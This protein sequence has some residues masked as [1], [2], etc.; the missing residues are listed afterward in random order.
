MLCQLSSSRDRE[1]LLCPVAVPSAPC[2]A[3]PSTS[4]QHSSH[5]LLEGRA[6]Q[7]TALCFQSP[8]FLKGVQHCHSLAHPKEGQIRE[9]QTC[10][11]LFLGDLQSKQQRSPAQARWGLCTDLQPAHLR[12]DL[13]SWLP[14]SSYRS[15]A[16]A[17]LVS[18]P[19][20][21]LS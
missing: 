7:T 14:T 5:R 13:F 20:F 4:G 17:L 8:S 16:W 2:K 6:R 18:S 1:V 12:L 15:E 9:G 19:H 11:Y 10:F 3:F 21:V